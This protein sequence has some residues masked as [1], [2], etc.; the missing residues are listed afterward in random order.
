MMELLNEP[1]RNLYEESSLIGEYFNIVFINSPLAPR[2]SQPLCGAPLN[3]SHPC[4]A[5]VALR[6]SPAQLKSVPLA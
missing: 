2:A 4:L 1:R 6:F 3:L 5:Q